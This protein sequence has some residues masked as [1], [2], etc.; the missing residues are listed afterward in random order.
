MAAPL[1]ADALLDADCSGNFVRALIPSVRQLS[2]LSRRWR[3]QP[4]QAAAAVARGARE[5]G[6][7]RGRAQE[8][9][10]QNALR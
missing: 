6:R 9:A 10:V 3:A 4:P 8:A 2:S 7:E 1:V 5:R